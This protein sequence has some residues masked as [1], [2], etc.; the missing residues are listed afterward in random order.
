MTSTPE[1]AEGWLRNRRQVAR[2]A[3]AALDVPGAERAA[4][5]VGPP[6]DQLGRA[7]DLHPRSP[8]SWTLLRGRVAHR[9][10]VIVRDGR[11]QDLSS[12]A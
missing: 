12:G 11:P 2:A 5:T 1:T 6:H 4:V 7:L 3:A 9:T 8:A 10:D